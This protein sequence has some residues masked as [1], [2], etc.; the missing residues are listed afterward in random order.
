MGLILVAAL[1]VLL[2]LGVPVAFALA[3]ATL[4][5]IFFFTDMSVFVVGQQMF[6]SLDSFPLLAIPLFILAGKLMETGGISSRLIKLASAFCGHI[7]GGYAASGV[8]ACL[9]FGAISGSSAATVAAIGA[10][11][12]PA[13]IK[14]GYS[15]SFSAASIAVSGELGVILPPSIP[16]IVYGVVAKVS[17]GSLFIAGILPGILL[18]LSLI[19]TVYIIAKIKGFKDDVR[20]STW[21]EKL[22]AVSDSSLAL[23]MPLIILGGIYS[24]VFTP[25]EAAAV[26]VVYSFVVSVFVY[27]ELKI[28]S[29]INVFGDAALM[30]A[31]IMIIVSGAGLMSWFLTINM[32]PQSIAEILVDVT[33]NV[34]IFLVIVNLILLIVGMFFESTSAILILAPI[35]VPVAMQFGIDPVHFGIIMIVNLAI[36][37]VTPPVGVNLFVSCQIAKISL[38]EIT[39]GLA[40]F[41]ITLIINLMLVT[42]IPIIST[43]LPGMMR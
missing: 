22:D 43:W 4:F 42:Y 23:I 5:A 34:V 15:S 11:L 13:M 26:A 18:G 9:F 28:Q 10:I 38:E 19:L 17:I 37:M 14:K 27:K 21:K 36:G 32:I 1:F 40:P 6:S 33:A 8:V 2:F 30:T 20:K 3:G 24:G 16:L 35:L 25:T 39:K 7:S 12:I 31:I 29:L 41:F